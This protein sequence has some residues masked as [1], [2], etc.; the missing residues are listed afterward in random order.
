M[1][2]FGVNIGKALRRFCKSVI[3]ASVPPSNE[4][5]A[6]CWMSQAYPQALSALMKIGLRREI[7]DSYIC[8]YWRGLRDAQYLIEQKSKKRKRS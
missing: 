4:L 3:G 5:H 8:G 1:Q 6:A 2:G 7:A